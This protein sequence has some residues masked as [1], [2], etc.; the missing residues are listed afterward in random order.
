MSSFDLIDDE[1]LCPNERNALKVF[2]DLAK[3][4]EWT[5]SD[6]WVDEYTSHCEW[7]GI[8]CNEANNSIRLDLQS[9]GLSGILTTRIGDLRSLEILNLNNNNIKASGV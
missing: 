5:A 3:G 1:I 8:K 6:F 2:F 9:N 7:Y 4:G